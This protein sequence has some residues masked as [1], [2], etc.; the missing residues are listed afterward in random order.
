MLY[1]VITNLSAD[2]DTEY[3]SDGITEDI[4]TQVSKIE[5]LRVIS[6]TSVLRYKNSDKAVKQIGAALNVG[7]ILEGSVR[8]SGARVRVT[9]Q[10]IDVRTEGHLWAERY[11]RA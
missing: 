2:P 3:F 5:H 1:E 10:L 11:D 6:R 4:I 8:K 9:A 7:Y